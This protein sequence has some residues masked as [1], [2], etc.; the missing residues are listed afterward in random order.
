MVVRYYGGRDLKL[1]SIL[2]IGH[3]DH[4]VIVVIRSRGLLSDRGERQGLY[5]I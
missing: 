1:Y 5:S 4:L 2:N 3:F